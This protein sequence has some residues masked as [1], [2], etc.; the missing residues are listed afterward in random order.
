MKTDRWQVYLG[1]AFLILSTALYSLQ[2]IIFHTARDITF[3][4]FQDLA[5]LPVE[6]LLVTLVVHR[7]LKAR[8]KQEQLRKM[9]MVI[10]AFFSEV[11]TSLINR[12]SCFIDDF[13]EFGRPLRVNPSWKKEQFAHTTHMMR[14]R[15]Y[16]IDSRRGDLPHLKKFMGEKREF[17]LRLLE[18]QNL[19]EHDTFTDLLWAVFHLTD[20]LDHREVLENLPSADMDHLSVDL[21]RAHTLL[22]IEWLAYMKYLK[23]DYPFLFSLAIRTNPSIPRLRL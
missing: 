14:T 8:E 16:G 1:A 9:N 13:V 23:T 6:V 22:V 10:G 5:F 12:L 15:D 7:L 21:K 17:L 2:Y 19:L 11:G 3:Y 4:F 20:E 18:N